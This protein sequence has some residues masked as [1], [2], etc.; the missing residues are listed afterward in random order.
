MAGCE[1]PNYRQVI[2]RSFNDDN[3]SIDVTLKGSG[4]IFGVDYDEIVFTYPTTTTEIF[5]YN[6]DSVQVQIIQ[7]TYINTTKKDISKVE[8]L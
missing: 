7:V 1:G 6:L 2:R 4:L 8:M 5:T 3:E